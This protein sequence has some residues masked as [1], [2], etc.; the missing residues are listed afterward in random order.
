MKVY[1]ER[2][3]REYLQSGLLFCFDTE[4]LRQNFE[5][6]KDLS[7]EEILEK[8]R[9]LDYEEEFDDFLNQN[10]FEGLKTEVS[11]TLKEADYDFSFHQKEELVEKI[12]QD[13]RWRW[14]QNFPH[15]E[16][17]ENKVFIERIPEINF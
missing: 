5:E 8:I 12:E 14:S 7:D 4:V 3:E 2:W 6:F 11:S 1:A 17:E 15:G 10:Y 13:R 9:S 16:S